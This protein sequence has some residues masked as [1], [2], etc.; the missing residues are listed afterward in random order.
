MNADIN[1]DLI[2]IEYR[3]NKCNTTISAC[4]EGIDVLFDNYGVRG[5]AEGNG[6]PIFI[7]YHEGHPRILIWSDI[8]KEDPTHI[9]SLEKASE[10]LR[11]Y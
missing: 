5:M 9:I 3:N 11:N 10:E 8:T 2:N 6:P 7:E 4:E 1:I